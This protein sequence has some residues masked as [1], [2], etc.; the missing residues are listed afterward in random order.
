M[1]YC[2]LRVLYVHFQMKFN[3]RLESCGSS[4]NMVREQCAEE[5]TVQAICL[6]WQVDRPTNQFAKNSLK[7]DR[8]RGGR[9]LALSVL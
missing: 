4:V 3:F 1:C 2:I 7:T 5:H 9:N 8:V 6:S